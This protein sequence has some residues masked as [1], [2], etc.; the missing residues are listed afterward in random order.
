M[1][2]IVLLIWKLFLRILVRFSGWRVQSMLSPNSTPYCIL[3]SKLICHSFKLNGNTVG[4]SSLAYC[5]GIDVL[6]D[7]FILC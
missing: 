5:V 4:W 1:M 3:I 2:R 6:A 7:M